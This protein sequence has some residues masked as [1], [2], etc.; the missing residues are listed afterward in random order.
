MSELKSQ[1]QARSPVGGKPPSISMRGEHKP[2]YP[3]GGSG[4]EAA[5]HTCSHEVEYC[6]SFWEK[7]PLKLF[8]LSSDGRENLHLAFLTEF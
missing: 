8:V 5:P 7:A 6:L 1:L 2:K 3:E 4:W